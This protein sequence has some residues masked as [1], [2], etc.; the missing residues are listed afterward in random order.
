MKGSARSSNQCSLQDFAWENTEKSDP[1]LSNSKNWNGNFANTYYELRTM[2]YSIRYKWS[3]VEKLLKTFW[4]LV[5]LHML[6]M[7]DVIL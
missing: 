3:V 2:F 4:H 5:R 1:E 7:M 6:Q